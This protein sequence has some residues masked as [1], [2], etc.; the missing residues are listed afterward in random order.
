[1]TK[2]VCIR[3][4]IGLFVAV[5]F[6]YGMAQLGL[7]VFA[8]KVNGLAVVLGVFYRPFLF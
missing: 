7:F 6:T 8:P 5:V 4:Y 2:Y 3:F 1:M